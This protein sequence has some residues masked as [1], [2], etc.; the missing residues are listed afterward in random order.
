MWAT[1]QRLSMLKAPTGITECAQRKNLRRKIEVPP[2]TR[3]RR[4]HGLRQSGGKA[5]STLRGGRNRCQSRTTPAPMSEDQNRK[6]APLMDT[7]TMNGASVSSFVPTPVF[8][9]RVSLPVCL[10]RGAESRRAGSG[11]ALGYPLAWPRSPHYHCCIPIFIVRF[12]FDPIPFFIV[13][14][15]LYSRVLPSRRETCPIVAST[16]STQTK[17]S[18]PFCPFCCEAPPSQKRGAQGHSR[19]LSFIH[20]HAI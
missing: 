8:T 6:G 5:E 4:E 15:P 12:Q 9:A 10:T 13:R 2:K 16:L 18:R 19:S 1:K 7:G 14:F 11:R 20:V 17:A 3:N